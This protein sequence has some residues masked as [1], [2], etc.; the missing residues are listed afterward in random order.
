MI[1][2]DLANIGINVPAAFEPNVPGRDIL[3]F[4]CRWWPACDSRI[5]HGAVHSRAR[6]CRAS[7]TPIRRRG[8]A[9]A[10]ARVCRRT[11]CP[12]SADLGSGMNFSGLN[13][14]ALDKDLDYARNTADLTTRAQDYGLADQRL[15]AL[16]PAIPLYQQVIV[17]TYSLNLRGVVQNDLVP[18]FDTAA[19]YVH[20]GRLR[21]LART[22]G[23]TAARI[24]RPRATSQRASTR[25]G[26]CRRCVVCRLQGDQSHGAAAHRQERGGGVGGAVRG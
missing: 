12:S 20:D 1:R 14:P 8:M 19:W 7:P 18:D 3:R 16:L 25:C 4:V 6:A 13:D 5:R 11:R 10:A 21:R 23:G 17:N 24:L 26:V 22:F 2:T 9:I 15:A